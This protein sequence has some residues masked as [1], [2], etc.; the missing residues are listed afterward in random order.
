MQ[1]AILADA[2]R[3]V[4]TLERVAEKHGYPLQV[5]PAY[6]LEPFALTVRGPAELAEAFT[7]V[8]AKSTTGEV[9]V[10]RP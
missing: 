8:V 5:I 4:D 3:D 7:T 2:I 9:G 10:R 1:A 6:A